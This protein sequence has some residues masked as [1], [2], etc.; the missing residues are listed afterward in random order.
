MAVGGTGMNGNRGM[1]SNQTDTEEGHQ[2]WRA[3]GGKGRPKRG[4]PPHLFINLP[5]STPCRGLVCA[6]TT[7]E[8]RQKFF[9]EIAPRE[10]ILLR[11]P[12]ECPQEPIRAFSVR[13]TSLAA[14][15]SAKGR[16]RQDVGGR[17][18]PTTRC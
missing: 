2:R 17:S 6:R 15:R 7:L 10:M 11:S 3:G 12:I 16:S 5:A 1:K 9:S 13:S 8:I 14:D 4:V 18:A